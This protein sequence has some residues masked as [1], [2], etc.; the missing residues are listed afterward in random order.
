MDETPLYPRFIKRNLIEALEDSPV[1]LIQGPRQSGKSTLAQLVCAP[2]NL[3][4][5]RHAQLLEPCSDDLSPRVLDYRYLTFDDRDIRQSAQYDPIGFVLD[6]PNHVILDEIQFVPELFN[7]IKMV[8]DRERSTGR[9][10]LTGSTHVLLNSNLSESLAGRMQVIR[11]HP[12]SQFEIENTRYGSSPHPTFLDA[13]FGDGFP[14]YQTDRLG[15]QLIERVCIGGFAPALSRPTFR[16]C[17]NWYR[18]YVE[19]LVQRDVQDLSRIQSA[20]I[21][22]RLLNVAAS[23]TARLFNVNQLA[24]PFQLSRLTIERYI[25]LLEQL[26]LLERLPPWHSNRLSRLVKTPKLHIGD[27]G[28]A[29]AVLRV[30]TDALAA[31]RY[32]LGQLV[33][34]FVYTEIRRQASWNERSVAFHHFRDKDGV[35]VDIVLEQSSGHVAGVEVKAAATV[36]H[37]DFRGLRKLA[38]ATGERFRRGVVLYDGEN[39]LK[40]GERLHAVPI[41]RLWDLS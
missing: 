41:S 13:L 10:L 12:L 2:K 25:A 11:L 32:M 36:T 39:C 3:E 37:A 24:A 1:V 21:L 30:D 31:N 28:L 17:A 8:V 23:Q 7:A 22:P 38:K 15:T 35:E 5:S 26:F 29:S 40:F 18:D 4:R 20:E 14:M 9:F 6:L 33:E 34:S 19:A 16:R 27:T